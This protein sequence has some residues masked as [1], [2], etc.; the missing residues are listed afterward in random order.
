[1]VPHP[2]PTVVTTPVSTAT[3]IL[4]PPGRSSAREVALA[5][6]LQAGPLP[7]PP[8]VAM[9]IVRATSNPDCEV[10]EIVNLLA[11]DPAICGQ[12]LKVINSCVYALSSPITSVERAVLLLGMNTVRSLVLALS[13]PAMQ[14]GMVPAKELRDYW[15]NSVSGAIM[16]RE[17]A[18]R[19]RRPLPE[20]D[21]VCGLLRDI[22]GLLIRQT[23][24]AEY[25]DFAAGARGRLATDVCGLERAVFGVDHADVSA[26]LL[27]EWKLPA[28]LV[29]PIRGH[30]HPQVLVN[31]TK[32]I[33]DRAEL[34]MF[35]E[36]LT[37]LDTVAQ[38]PDA[39]AG[40]LNTAETK[41]K[42][43]RGEL[44]GFLESLVPK[45]KAFAEMLSLDV[46]QS[47]D[48]VGT[49]TRGCT[50]LIELTRGS[51]SGAATVVGG[52]SAADRTTAGPTTPLPLPTRAAAAT[53][54]AFHPDFLSRFPDGGCH[55]D[56]YQLK[57]VLGRGAMGVV[58]LGHDPGLDRPVAV[59]LMD[60]EVARDPASRTRFAREAKSV[61]AVQHENVV[62]IYAVRDADGLLY[63][64]MEY[65]DGCSLEEVVERTGKLPLDELIAAA[66]QTAAGLGAAHARG[67]IHRDL[68]PANVL[69]EKGGRVK[70]VDFGLARSDK[71]ASVSVAGS[72]VGTPLFMSPEQ[73][74]GEPLD[75]RSDLFSLGTVLH[76]LATG[77][78]PFAGT[79]TVAVMKKVADVEPPPLRTLRPD[80]PEWFEKVVLRLH[81]KAPAHRY[82]TA[83][84]VVTAIRAGAAATATTTPAPGPADA[85]K[86]KKGWFGW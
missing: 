20:D 43:P 41:F 81:A 19:M 5:R 62:Q 13:L 32:T 10:K 72:V 48:Y 65:I 46:G 36:S 85:P 24:P 1:M 76:V 57:K 78:N 54:P 55:L 71:D 4:P 45:V 12:L 23:F 6:V 38:H 79:S 31:P 2:V 14:S 8:A 40:V 29:E 35:T 9:Q 17:L 74:Y 27:G 18:A 70:L 61:A 52:A 63:L 34:L 60:P 16:A 28:L 51:G 3:A 39:L 75:H 15:V 33:A 26:A 80:V 37:Q 49:L 44:V 69:R 86:K 56:G 11:H 30:H 50:A 53:G 58:F 21:L 42:L 47:P 25:T 68:K 66:E 67:I 73:V 84:E 82:A 64:A 22:G 83:D 7:T 59:K 77:K